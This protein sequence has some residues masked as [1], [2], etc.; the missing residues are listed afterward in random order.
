MDERNQP[1]GDTEEPRDTGVELVPGERNPEPS[2]PETPRSDGDW[3]LWPPSPKMQIV[4]I[5][6]AFG[7]FNFILLAIWAWVMVRQF[8]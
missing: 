8:G 4:L 3:T 1:A 2:E 5:A 7:I 6:A